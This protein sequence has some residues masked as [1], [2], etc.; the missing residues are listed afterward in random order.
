L[1]GRLVNLRLDC[2]ILRT[3]SATILYWK[4]EDM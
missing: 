3:E 4:S 2:G 1:L